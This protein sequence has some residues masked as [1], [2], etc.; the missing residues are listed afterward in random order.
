MMSAVTK[1]SFGKLQNKHAAT[2]EPEGYRREEADEVASPS[3]DDGCLGVEDVVHEGELHLH[4]MVASSSWTEES[5]TMAR[6][7]KLN[8]L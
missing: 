6:R 3:V 4:H 7:Q 8:K 1:Q 5:S 2:P